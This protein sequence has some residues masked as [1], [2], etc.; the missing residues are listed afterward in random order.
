MMA[1]CSF[2][3]RLH[4]SL[5]PGKLTLVPRLRNTDNKSFTFTF[6]MC[7]YLSVSDIRFCN[8][9]LDL[10]FV[11]NS[12]DGNCLYYNVPL[13][14]ARKFHLAFILSITAFWILKIGYAIDS[15]LGCQ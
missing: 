10:F 5:G 9:T 14:D 1:L 3:L 4:I 6:S 2:E 12:D 8:L 15:S 11:W 13:S 7:N